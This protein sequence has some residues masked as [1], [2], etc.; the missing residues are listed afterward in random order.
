MNEASGGG[1]AATGGFTGMYVR[2]SEGIFFSGQDL[3][4]WI[5]FSDFIFLPYGE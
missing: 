3:L 5:S 2:K 4:F 1:M